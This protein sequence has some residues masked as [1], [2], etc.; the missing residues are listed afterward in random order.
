MGT[1]DRC[2][3]DQPMAVGRAPQPSFLGLCFSGRPRRNAVTHLPQLDLLVR[4]LQ[5][6]V[7]RRVAVAPDAE[8]EG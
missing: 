4:Q 5:L 2:A 1:G 6:H 7:H 8:R 3:A